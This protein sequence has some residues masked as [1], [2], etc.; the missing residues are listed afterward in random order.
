MAFGL[1]KC[2]YGWM[3]RMP[4]QGAMAK[5]TTAIWKCAGGCRAAS[6]NVKH[7]LEGGTL[8]TDVV[9]GSRQVGALMKRLHRD[10]DPERYKEWAGKRGTLVNTVQSWMKAQ[11]WEE[12]EEEEWKWAHEGLGMAI[13]LKESQGVQRRKEVMHKVREGWRWRNWEKFRPAN[14]RDANILQNKEYDE[15]GSQRPERQC[16]RTQGDCT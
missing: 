16:K 1:A 10:G 13:D 8:A 6:R 9:I 12:D 15:I 3:A 7:L 14:R 5:V 2:T 4:P 11:G